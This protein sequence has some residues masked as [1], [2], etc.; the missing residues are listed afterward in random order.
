MI[1][2]NRAGHSCACRGHPRLLAGFQQ[3]GVDGWDKPGHD[4]GERSVKSCEPAYPR[5]RAGEGNEGCSA[6]VRTT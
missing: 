2:T 6:A 1:C 5:P 4:S 3:E